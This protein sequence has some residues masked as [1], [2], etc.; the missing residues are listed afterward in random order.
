MCR[1]VSGSGGGAPQAP[2]A[3]ELGAGDSQEAGAMP[4]NPPAGAGGTGDP[5]LGAAIPG[6]PAFE[7]APEATPNK[8]GGG[9]DLADPVERSPPLAAAEGAASGSAGGISA[10]R[11]PNKVGGL[12]LG[13]GA[14]PSGVVGGAATGAD[15]AVGVAATAA[16]PAAIISFGENPNNDGGLDILLPPSDDCDDDGG[17]GAGTAGA[18]VGGRKIPADTPN[19]VGGLNEAPAEDAAGEEGE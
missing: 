14:A 8:V 6:N 2:P 12:K 5:G 16:A 7:I 1:S 3:G 15:G 4:G 18:A 9:P 11:S 13:K 19:K 10:A 17:A